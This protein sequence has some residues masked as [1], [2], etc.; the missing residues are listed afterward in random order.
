MQDISFIDISQYYESIKDQIKIKIVLEMYSKFKFK[1][2]SLDISNEEE[3]TNL[4]DQKRKNIENYLF[5]YLQNFKFIIYHYPNPLD[6]FQKSSNNEFHFNSNPTIQSINA[7]ICVENECL[8]IQSENIF[9]INK[10]IDQLKNLQE[11]SILN[12]SK[13]YN[14]SN[15][16]PTEN[17]CIKHFKKKY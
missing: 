11:I 13:K 3:D 12:A 8:V 2:L 17:N 15:Y 4:N 5:K 10:I 14:K 9:N 6:N 7:V 16:S 1:Y